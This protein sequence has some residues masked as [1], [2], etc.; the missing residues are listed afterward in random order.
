MT[1]AMYTQKSGWIILLLLSIGYETRFSRES[2]FKSRMS[3]IMVAPK[4]KISKVAYRRGLSIVQKFNQSNF[5][6]WYITNIH[7]SN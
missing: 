6:G 4:G 1:Y 7:Y 3:N 5:E 2:S